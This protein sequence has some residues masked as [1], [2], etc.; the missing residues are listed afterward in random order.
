[1][2]RIRVLLCVFFI[3]FS[4]NRMNHYLK[5]VLEEEYMDSV[6]VIRSNNND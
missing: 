4:P 5:T 6:T 1:M 3:A 2:I